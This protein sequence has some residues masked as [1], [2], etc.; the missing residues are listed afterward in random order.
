V[1][2]KATSLGAVGAPP[3]GV[4]GAACGARRDTRRGMAREGVQTA[5][6]NAPL[7]KQVEVSSK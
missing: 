7:L 4:I 3:N 6:S 1:A 2:N 5:R